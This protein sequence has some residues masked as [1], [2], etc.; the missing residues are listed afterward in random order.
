LI[1]KCRL[2]LCQRSLLKVFSHDE[3]ANILG[4]PAKAFED[5]YPESAMEIKRTIFEYVKTLRA[6]KSRCAGAGAGPTSQDILAVNIDAEGF[7]VAPSPVSWEKISKDD[8][9]R[10]YRT[11]MTLHYRMF[12][13]TCHIQNVDS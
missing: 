5:T 11:Y 4:V 1:C 2:G 8:L 6:Q 7:P 3:I 9:E 10:M 12:E 13:C